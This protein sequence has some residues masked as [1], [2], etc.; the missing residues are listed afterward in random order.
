[1]PRTDIERFGKGRPV[2]DIQSAAQGVRKKL[3]TGHARYPL[4][5]MELFATGNPQEVPGTRQISIPRRVSRDSSRLP[6]ASLLRW[7]YS[8][9]Q[10]RRRATL[11]I[12]RRNSH[13]E[14][15]PR[16]DIAD[17]V[18]IEILELKL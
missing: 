5:I 18:P 6:S 4:E 15:Q 2:S 16:E 7:N 11:R 17:S 3:D 8:D 13:R 10:P 12:L 9:W 14:P 1:M